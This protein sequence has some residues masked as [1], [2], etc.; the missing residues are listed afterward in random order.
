[1]TKRHWVVVGIGLAVVVVG[2]GL[3]I[4]AVALPNG[5]SCGGAWSSS[6]VP[7]YAS[8]CSDARSGKGMVAAV[9]VGV[10]VLIAAAGAV[11]AYLTPA[12][13]STV[14]TSG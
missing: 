13:A 1:M 11:S 10:G 6:Y 12:K 3:G 7:Y 8:E 9:V 2:V 4:S 5:V 14:P